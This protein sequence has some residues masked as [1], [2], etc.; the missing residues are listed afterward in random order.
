L[1]PRGEDGNRFDLPSPF[2]KLDLKRCQESA[3]STATECEDVGEFRSETDYV[4]SSRRGA[5]AR[6]CS[7]VAI[8]RLCVPPPISLP[9]IGDFPADLQ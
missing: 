3:A 4:H 7:S 8:A 9:E 1:A 5:S 2:G 6:S